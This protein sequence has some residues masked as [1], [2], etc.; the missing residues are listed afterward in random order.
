MGREAGSEDQKVATGGDAAPTMDSHHSH[1]S[2]RKPRSSK[3]CLSFPAADAWK[4]EL[5]SVTKPYTTERKGEILGEESLDSHG[6]EET[7]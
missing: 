2:L 6:E 3:T 4:E 5:P 7:W 1:P